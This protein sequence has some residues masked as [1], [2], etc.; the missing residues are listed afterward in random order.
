MSEKV[1]TEERLARL[2]NAYE[3][4]EIGSKAKIQR[5]APHL[6]GDGRMHY[7]KHFTPKLMSLGPIHYGAPKLQ[8]GE[9]YKQM[10]ASMYLSSTDKTP[11]FLLGEI[12]Q[13]VEALKELFAPDLFTGN[14]LFWNYSEQGFNSLEEMISWTLLVDGCALLRILEYAQPERPEKMNVKDEQLSPVLQDVLLLENQLPYPLLKL[15]WRGTNMELIQT[16]KQFLMLY[17]W[18]TANKERI[19]FEAPTHLLDLH[20]SMILYDNPPK[21]TT[22]VKTEDIPPQKTQYYNST[23]E[24]WITYRN[25]T[26]L[27]AAGVEVKASKTR[28][29]KDVTFSLGR[30]RSELTLPE[31]IVDENTA[32]FTLNLI[33]YETCP[34]FANFEFCN[35]ISFLNSFIDT[36]DDV[37]A[38]RSAGVLINSLGSDKDVMNLFTTINSNLVP[39]MKKYAHVMFQIEKHYRHKSLPTWIALAYNTYFS[40]PWT[41]IALFAALLGLIL[42]FIQ[43]WCTLHPPK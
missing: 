9:E 26:E 39:N 13:N 14:H 21:Y 28:N 10:W 38:L 22:Y 7:E 19:E 11:E 8:L 27:K 29:V 35:H 33:A 18:A 1:S 3:R 36:P 2:R 34:D 37:K 40:N 24:F 25:I 23:E 15:L 42:T 5:V 4:S 30:F 6:V 43:T 31:M 20:R 41:I 32:S 16:M 17:E 12:A